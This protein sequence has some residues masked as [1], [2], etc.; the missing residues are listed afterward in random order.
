MKLY[1]I[2][3]DNKNYKL[4]R[5]SEVEQTNRTYQHLDYN[6]K[7]HYEIKEICLPDI[8]YSEQNIGK[9]YDINTQTFIN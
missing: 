8:E 6:T 7:T 2:F 5:Y 1:G 9:N 3:D 4:L